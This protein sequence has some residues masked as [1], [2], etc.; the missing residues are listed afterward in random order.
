[1]AKIA[2]RL[3]KAHKMEFHVDDSVYQQIA[4]RC[5]EVDIGARAIDH[6]LDKHVLPVLS[7]KLLEM[8]VEDK[9][10]K[11]VSMGTDDA[12]EFTYSFTD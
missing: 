4:G 9:M 12:G 1:V 8:M 7:R 3:S 6:I 5:T 11:A 10:P 2:K